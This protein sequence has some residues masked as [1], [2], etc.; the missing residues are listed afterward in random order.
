MAISGPLSTPV[1]GD[2]ASTG[3]SYNINVASGFNT[4]DL[5]VA[6]FTNYEVEY[7]T[8]IALTGVTTWHLA[9]QVQL[10][11]GGFGTAEIWYGVATSTESAGTNNAAITLATSVPATYGWGLISRWA[12]V[13]TTTPLDTAATNTNQVVTGSANETTPS[14]SLAG[15][16]E[17]IIA[18][19]GN[20]SGDSNVWTNGFTDLSTAWYTANT[21]YADAAY[22]I[23][24]S[25]GSISTAV[26]SNTTGHY[27]SAIAAF[28][29]ATVGGT[30]SAFF[31]FF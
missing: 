6:C 7:V 2:N 18:I 9:A 21:G 31:E 22:L 12:G 4:G 29:P 19:I 13:N 20:T 14:L 17:L 24:S 23:N 10:T 25:G 8:A 30:S 15:A 27:S 3:A 26:P 11:S 28:I 16:G 5:L 1:Y